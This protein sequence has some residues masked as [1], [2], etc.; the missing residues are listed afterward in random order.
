MGPQIEQ[1]NDIWY[2]LEKD[3]AMSIFPESIVEREKFV[4]DQVMLGNFEAKWTEISY[5]IGDKTI[6]LNVMEDALKI[7]GVRVNVSATLEQKLADLFGASLLTPQV[8]DLIYVS[9]TRRADPAPMPISFSVASMTKHSSN[10]DSRLIGDGLA[11]TVGKHWVLDKQLE[12][13]PKAACNYGWH[14]TGPSFQGIKGFPCASK[15]NS[16]NSNPVRVIQP[17]ATAHDAAHQDYSQICQL[18]SQVCWINDVE[19]RFS[20]VLADV[21]LN[22]L[23]SHQGP[24]KVLRQP[25]VLESSKGVRVLFPVSVGPSA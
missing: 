1:S 7:S 17:N 18:V 6:R 24:L 12:T 13:K 16:C 25:G 19:Y 21:D 3:Q 8:A 23:V 14:F 20:D 2:L 22:V 4:L 5:T 10:V 9:A 11:S 15:I